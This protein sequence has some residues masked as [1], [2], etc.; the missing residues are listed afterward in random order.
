M[1]ATTACNHSALTSC[2]DQLSSPLYN[3]IKYLCKKPIIQQTNKKT[4]NQNLKQ[5][6]KQKTRAKYINELQIEVQCSCFPSLA[7]GT[8][9]SPV[10]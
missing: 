5:K 7:T 1:L 2:L 3:G 6:T 9:H 8:S 10:E 4:P